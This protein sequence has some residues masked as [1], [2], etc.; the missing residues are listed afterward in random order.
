MHLI[1]CVVAVLEQREVCRAL[2]TV[3]DAPAAGASAAAMINEKLLA[4]LSLPD[5]TIAA[6]VMDV[7]S[8]YRH[9]ISVRTKNPQEVR[10][11]F[12][13]SRIGVFGPP[14]SIQMG[15]GGEWDHQ[16][17]VPWFSSHP[18]ILERRNSLARG[19]YN[20]LKEGDPFSNKQVPR[21]EQ[22]R[23]NT[24]NSAGS[25]PATRWFF[26]PI[27]CIFMDGVTRTRVWRLRRIPRYQANLRNNGSCA[28]WRR[29]EL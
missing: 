25:F 21:K 23:L 5:D 3:P 19:I 22:W 1:T 4:D 24:L 9:L 12:C 26:D 29:G 8:K 10:D 2:N 15:E 7:F 16:I 13:I 11:A 14:M 18:W 17:I 6:H 28:R 20:R 27:L